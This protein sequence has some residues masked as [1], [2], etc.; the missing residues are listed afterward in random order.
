MQQGRRMGGSG[1]ALFSGA[2]EYEANLFR[3]TRLLVDEDSEFRA[4]LTWIDLADLHLLHARE[5]V[6]RIAYVSLRPEWV[7]VVFPAQQTSALLCNGVPLLLGDMICHG[8]GERFYQRTIG[9]LRGRR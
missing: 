8:P 2:D 5:T 4:Q 7:S 6:P 9:A 1:S 3:T